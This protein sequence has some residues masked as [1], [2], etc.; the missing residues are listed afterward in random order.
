MRRT[1]TLRE[2]ISNLTSTYRFIDI[3]SIIGRQ[4]L[5]SDWS[6][7]F[8]KI[9]LTNDDS[10]KIK[11]THSSRKESLAIE[12]NEQSRFRFQNECID[13]QDV[14][15]IVNEIQT[16]QVTISGITSRLH[17]ARMKR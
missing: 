9:R 16:G 15:D 2:A 13:I 10:E 4:D 8:C 6:C 17:A 3:R 12:D 11:N 14:D 1:T 5:T 7:I